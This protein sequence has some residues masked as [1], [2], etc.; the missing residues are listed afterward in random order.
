M[1]SAKMFL[2]IRRLHESL[3]NNGVA[4]FVEHFKSLFP[5]SHMKDLVVDAIGP[6]R[7]IVVEGRRVVNFGSDS[8]LGLDQDPRVQDAIIRGVQKWGTHNGSSRAFMSVRANIEAEEKLAD[9]LG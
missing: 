3:R 5:D 6:G 4:R 7:E 8:F 2:P 1:D 9:W